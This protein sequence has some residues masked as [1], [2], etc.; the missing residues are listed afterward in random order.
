M[1]NF[2]LWLKEQ[3]KNLFEFITMGHAEDW[4]DVKAS[5]NRM[6]NREFA[7]RGIRSTYVANMK[8]GKTQRKKK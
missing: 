8:S 5:D 7:I 6:N 2:L 3:D 4:S 1:D